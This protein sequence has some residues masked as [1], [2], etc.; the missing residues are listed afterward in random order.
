[1]KLDFDLSSYLEKIKKSSSYFHTFINRD[2]LAVGL[3]VLQSGEE[4]TQT[5]HSSDEVY[6]IISGDGF[7]R[8]KNKDYPVSKDRLF[9]VAKNV[10]HF[11]HGNTCE[12]R[13]LYFFG[14]PDN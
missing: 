14:G 3:L 13:A 4:D 5:P 1:M 10:E 7:L 6:L 2:S 11:F 12:L 8:I 9:F